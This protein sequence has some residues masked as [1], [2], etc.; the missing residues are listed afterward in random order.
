[1]MDQVGIVHS[2]CSE[3]S[4]R[5]PKMFILCMGR[6]DCADAKKTGGMHLVAAPEALQSPEGKRKVLEVTHAVLT[7]MA[8]EAQTSDLRVMM[9][10]VR[11]LG[12]ACDDFRVS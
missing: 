1:M 2:A 12:L 11:A 8:Q 5:D 7:R 3:A 6:A 4:R 10:K 9:E